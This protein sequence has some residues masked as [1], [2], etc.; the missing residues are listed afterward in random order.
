[1]SLLTVIERCINNIMAVIPRSRP[2][3]EALGEARV[4][5]H[6]GAHDRHV[7]E[8]TDAAFAR[9]LSCHCWGIE[10]DVRITA[11]GVLVVHH[12]PTLMRLWQRPDAI[13]DLSFQALRE[14]VP[15]IPSLPEVISRY[16]RRLHLFIELKTQVDEALLYD[17]LKTLTPIDDYH[18]ISLDDALLRPLTRFPRAALL[19]VPEHHNVQQ[20]CTLS[21]KE[22][23]GGV[24]GHY[25]LLSNKKIKPLMAAR[26]Q[27]G[28]GFIDSKNSLY[29]E[30]NRGIRWV[31]T[32]RAQP[33]CALLSK[34][35]NPQ[36]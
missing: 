12:D 11:D 23:Y 3:C 8:N 30:L 9:A 19:L 31:F 27:V 25:L 36:R 13:A 1:M 6:R 22:N 14:R 29:R 15:D 4:I 24:L 17:N 33:I 20:F 5:A 10:L 26:Q 21:L 32:N 16:G 28:V 35:V 7:I 2:S 18:L 34:V